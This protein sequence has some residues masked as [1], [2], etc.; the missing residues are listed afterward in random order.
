MTLLAKLFTQPK[1]PADAALSRQLEESIESAGY[2][3]HRMP[4]EAARLARK[5][6][7]YTTASAVLSFVT[8]LVVWPVVDESSQLTAQVLVCVMSGL[9][10][11]AVAIPHALGLSDRSDESIRLC[12]AY[13]EVYR[14]LLDARHRFTAGSRTDASRWADVIRRFEG[15]QRRKEVLALEDGDAHTERAFA[16]APANGGGWPGAAVPGESRQITESLLLP[17]RVPAPG[18]RTVAVDGVAADDVAVLAALVHMLTNGS[19][20]RHE[21]AYVPVRR[22]YPRRPRARARRRIHRAVLEELAGRGLPGPV[23]T[24]LGSSRVRVTK[25]YE[26]VRP[27]L[28]GGQSPDPAMLSG[29]TP[30]THLVPPTLPASP[31]VSS[32]QLS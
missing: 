1:D 19:G 2:W 3:V 22:R 10:A 5:V 20:G 13:A 14:E 8:A 27:G 6:R 21:P 32:Q 31:P 17:A 16:A 7:R 23:R 18:G 28:A 24:I 15:I 4:R 29:V 26:S 12:G 9:A 25:G 30:R 11:L